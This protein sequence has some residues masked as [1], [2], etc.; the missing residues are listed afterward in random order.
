MQAIHFAYLHR[1]GPWAGPVPP[2]CSGKTSASSV[3]L[4]KQIG[5]QLS[6]WLITRRHSSIHS[7]RLEVNEMIF[8]LQVARDILGN[9]ISVLITSDLS[10]EITRVATTLDGF[11]L[12]T[13]LLSPPLTRYERSF[14]QA[15]HASPGLSHNLTVT[16]FDETGISETARRTWVDNI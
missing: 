11:T 2:T 15:G 9:S 7:R 5:G 6:G 13:D 12:G 1:D 14:R 4:D 3:Q 10:R 8:S 16:A